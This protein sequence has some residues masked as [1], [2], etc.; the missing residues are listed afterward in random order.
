MIQ[1]TNNEYSVIPISRTSKG[2]VN[3]PRNR[4]S[5]K[6]KLLRYY[7]HARDFEIRCSYLGSIALMRAKN[8]FQFEGVSNCRELEKSGQTYRE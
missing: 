6:A 2:N 4:K 3:K 1:G 5:N 8:C 7:F